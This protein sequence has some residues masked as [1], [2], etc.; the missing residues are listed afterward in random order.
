MKFIEFFDIKAHNFN[1]LHKNEINQKSLF[2]GILYLLFLISMVYASFYFLNLLISKEK[3]ITTN[4]EFNIT[5][6]NVGNLTVFPKNEIIRGELYWVGN[7]NNIED[8]HQYFRAYLRMSGKKYILKS[9]VEYPTDGHFKRIRVEVPL[10]LMTFNFYQM[11][12][13]LLNYEFHWGFDSCFM[14]SQKDEDEGQLQNPEELADCNKNF[15]EFYI[16]NKEIIPKSYF[17]MWYYINY[18]IIDEKGKE[19]ILRES[20]N[21]MRFDLRENIEESFI[22]DFSLVKIKLDES[23][24]FADPKIK[25]IINYESIY[26]EPNF[27]VGNYNGYRNKILLGYPRNSF[28]IVLKISYYKVIDILSFLGGLIKIAQIITLIKLI[29][30]KYHYD[31]IY[32]YLGYTYYFENEK[33]KEF[34]ESNN[35]KLLEGIN[36]KSQNSK[37][38]IN[39]QSFDKSEYL[40]NSSE[41]NFNDFSNS[42]IA[43]IKSGNFEGIINFSKDK[44]ISLDESKEVIKN[45]NYQN[46]DYSSPKNNLKTPEMENDLIK[47]DIGDNNHKILKNLSHCMRIKIKLKSIFCCCLNRKIYNNLEEDLKVFKNLSFYVWIKIKLKCILCS[48]LNRKKYNNLEEHLQ[49]FRNFCSIEKMLY[50]Y[51]KI[52][53]LMKVFESSK[54]IE[55]K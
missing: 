40:L 36:S 41:A 30:N 52:E 12:P 26:K 55:K 4:L 54:D 22:H 49:I 39:K 34:Y 7:Q 18:T 5:E 28:F 50:E 23:Y 53:K 35:K 11:A 29:F 24:F 6:T 42:E 3:I 10:H 19:Q 47:N 2:G 16:R 51:K 1:L 46:Q 25:Y 43:N 45:K 20:Q 9:Y 33:I 48:C 27:N 32:S 17:K 8:F 38:C 31:K 37:N 44:N 15:Q 14:L 13:S 21:I